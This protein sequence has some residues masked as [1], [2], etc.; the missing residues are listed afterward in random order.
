[1]KRHLVVIF[2]LLLAS[3]VA[4]E[5]LEEQEGDDPN[6]DL[7]DDTGD[8]DSGDDDSGD[9]DSGDDDGWDYPYYLVSG[10]GLSE[11][12]DLI[13]IQSRTK[14]TIHRDV[15]QTG[16]AINQTQVYRGE[17]Y[18]L[19]SLSHSMIVYNLQDLG[20]EREITIGVGNNPMV[21][22]FHD[23]YEA[24]VS[25][26]VSD[27]VTVF[28]LDPDY[29]GERLLATIAVPGD[30]ELPV[31][32]SGTATWARPGGLEVVG[33][34]VFVALS[35]LDGEFKASGP[36]V[37]AVIDA[38]TYKLEKSIGLVGR[39]PIAVWYD[40]PTERI[41]ITGAGD[42]IVGEGFAGNGGVDVLDVATETLVDWVD[43]GGGP[44]DIVVCPNRRAFVG[45]GREAIVLSF[46]ADTY[47]LLPSI[48]IKDPTIRSACPTPRR[49]PA[50]AT[51]C[52]TRPTSTTTCCSS[53]IPRTT[54][55]S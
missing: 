36:G 3:F 5:P 51:T 38:D 9:D 13:T 42:W 50:T 7:D 30:G 23:P 48:D 32:D 52:C 20:I 41:F 53:S 40:E 8:D 16:S 46:D 10:N 25:N 49:W 12:I 24:F 35:N 37:L 1:M 55:A 28:N 6:L 47:D 43:T 34:R 21:A 29:E 15:R 44:F 14:L 17:F 4:C 22:R 18:A 31:D 27:D 54:T 26:F 45:N 33:D 11:T 19:C 2:V 39:D